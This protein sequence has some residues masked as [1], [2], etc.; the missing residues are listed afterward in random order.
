MTIICLVAAAAAVLLFST[1]AAP[2][3]F[4]I[5]FS[6]KMPVRV[7]HVPHF[8]LYTTGEETFAIYI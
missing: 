7:E 2:F 5:D 8:C 4:A 1:S 6:S 3:L